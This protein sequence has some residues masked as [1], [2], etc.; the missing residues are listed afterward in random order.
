MRL[1]WPPC[2]IIQQVKHPPIQLGILSTHNCK[3]AATN[4]TTAAT[5]KRRP[6]DPNSMRA[7]VKVSPWFS[8][9]RSLVMACW[10]ARGSIWGAWKMRAS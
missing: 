4:K 10:Q 3:Q 6:F 7:L 2:S 1:S 5:N 9:Y 8:R